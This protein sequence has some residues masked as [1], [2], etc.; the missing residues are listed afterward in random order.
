M[1]SS[2]TILNRFTELYNEFREI[3]EKKLEELICK[4]QA[5][6]DEFFD[7]LKIV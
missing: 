7:A 6:P 5:T 3:Y 4:C 1:S 2:K